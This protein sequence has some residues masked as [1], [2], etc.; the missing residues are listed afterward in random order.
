MDIGE[1]ERAI[2]GLVVEDAIKHAEQVVLCGVDG[3]GAHG[4][5]CWAVPRKRGRWERSNDYFSITQTQ[6]DHE[7]PRREVGA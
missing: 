7:R 6:A 1:E 5:A 4:R 2:P 3:I